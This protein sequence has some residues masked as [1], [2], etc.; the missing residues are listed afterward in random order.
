MTL[1]WGYEPSKCD[2]DFCIGDCDL[3]NKAEEA[4]E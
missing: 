2:G 3:C 1:K 4:E